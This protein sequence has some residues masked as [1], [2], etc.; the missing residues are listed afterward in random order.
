LIESELFGRE[1]GSFTGAER[2]HAGYFER[3]HGGTLFLDEI[4]EL[5]APLQATLLRVLQE[6]TCE[7]AGGRQPLTVDI[8][9]IAAT[10]RDLRE[11]GISLR[12]LQYR[13]K[14]YGIGRE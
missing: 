4:G 5:D 8:R 12:T 9:L 6:R 14:E 3:A 11:L 2:Q 1:R 13:I 10:N 7:R